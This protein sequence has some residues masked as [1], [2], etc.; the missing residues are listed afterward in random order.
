L[1]VLQAPL[2]IFSTEWAANNVGETSILALTHL[3]K[4]V[5]VFYYVVSD[6]PVQSQ[7][8]K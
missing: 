6:L 1:P 2:L 3:D 4:E 8:T 7:L 5:V